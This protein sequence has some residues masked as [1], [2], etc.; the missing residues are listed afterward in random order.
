MPRPE[1]IENIFGAYVNQDTLEDAATWL[2]SNARADAAY[3]EEVLVALRDAEERGTAGDS[4]VIAAV[5]RSGYLVSNSDEAV[6]LVRE[7]RCLTERQL[8]IHR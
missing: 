2:A 7:L 4:S 6:E 8:Q 1:T 5:N 3:R